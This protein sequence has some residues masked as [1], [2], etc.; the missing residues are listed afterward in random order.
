MSIKHPNTQG[1]ANRVVGSEQ[2]GAAASCGDGAPRGVAWLPG[3]VCR[4]G[5]GVGAQGGGASH[6]HRRSTTGRQPSSYLST[7]VG[8]STCMDPPN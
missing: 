1:A 5:G 6:R 7:V 4:R 2:R 8:S 3:P